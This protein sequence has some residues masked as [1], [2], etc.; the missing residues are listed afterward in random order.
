M[1]Q[2]FKRKAQI[3]KV[4]ALADMDNGV[5][6][7]FFILKQGEMERN[8]NYEACQGISD[9]IGIISIEKKLHEN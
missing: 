8:E 6:A 3:Y 4:L 2:K 9:A 7:S 5:P 1:S